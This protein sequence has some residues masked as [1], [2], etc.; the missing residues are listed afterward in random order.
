MRDAAVGFQCPDCVS[1][2]AKETR[3]GLTPFGGKR[4]ANPQATSIGLIAINVAIW[5][6]V[7][8][9]G[10]AG[11]WLADQ[12]MLSPL[13]SCLANDPGTWFPNATTAELCSQV[14]GASWHP[15]LA[16]GAFWQV[17]TH[18]FVHVGIW[19]IALNA[20]GLWILGPPVERVL[21][22]ARFLAVY[23]LSTLGAGAT[24]FAFA[25]V[26]SSTLGASGGV[27]GLMGALLL[28]S[29]RVGGDVRGLLML[30]ALNAFITVTIP[31]ISWQGH[32]GGFVAGAVATAV[33]V[34][35]PKGPHRARWQWAGLAL[36]GLV[37]AAAFVARGLAL[38]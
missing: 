31:G 20:M 33:L 23:L 19:H 26:H 4:S 30:L 12:L 34:L 36:I 22:R 27:F 35:A 2:G 1:E 15:G 24:V 37:I 17:L 9:T 29:W 38:A 8:A 10:G 13:G 25:D 11:S 7:V 28:I 3:Q 14:P 16:D 5:V 21:G 32:L 6:A 18:G